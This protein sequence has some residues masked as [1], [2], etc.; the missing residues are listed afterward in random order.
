MLNLKQTHCLLK[1]NF[2]KMYWHTKGKPLIHGTN[3]HK[4]THLQNRITYELTELISKKETS[5]EEASGLSRV[6]TPRRQSIAEPG[7]PL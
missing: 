6:P 2:Q 1:L 4:D 3:Q 7:T 5:I